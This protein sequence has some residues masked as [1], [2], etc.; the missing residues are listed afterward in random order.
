MDFF[1]EI[2]CSL[3]RFPSV[4][5]SHVQWHKVHILQKGQCLSHSKTIL[6][7]ARTALPN[8]GLG[9]WLSDYL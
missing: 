2:A 7:N 6:Q 8:L 3:F 4:L 5:A 9:K 1:A